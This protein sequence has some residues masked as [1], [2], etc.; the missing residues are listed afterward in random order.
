M[1]Y[2]GAMSGTS[3]DAID[4][5]LV[6]FDDPQA[7]LIEYSESPYREGLREALRSVSAQSAIAEV[8][9]LDIELGHAF[10]DAVIAL[11]ARAHIRPAQVCAIGS[12]GQTVLHLPREPEKRTLQIGDPSIIANKTGIATVADFRRTNMAAGG[13]GAPL[14]PAFHAFQ[15]RSSHADRIILNLGGIAN[16]TLLPAD[17][18]IDPSG[19]D[20]GPGNGLLDDWNRRHNNTAMD[21]DGRWAQTGRPDQDL[22]AQFCNDPYFSLPPPKST[23]RDYFNLA[24][25]DKALDNYGKT[26]SANDVQATLLQLTCTA[27]GNA[28]AD[29]AGGAVELYVCG[30]GGNN[31]F[32]LDTLKSLLPEL[33]ISS[34]AELG[35]DPN[36]VEAVALAWLAYCRM[37]EIAVDLKSITGAKENIP[38]GAVYF[39]GVP[40]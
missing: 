32:M 7:R 8:S 18:A 1:Y 9:R 25:L 19:F 12:H 26:P 38:L 29:Y 3:M 27:I 28:V 11:L 21:T 5:A 23:G 13:E 39:G 4:I 34:T 31:A 6:D 36:A 30:G 16:I 37:N 17:G 14:A 2:I 22:L 10:A 15:F 24:W 33:R 20:T 40:R 35:L